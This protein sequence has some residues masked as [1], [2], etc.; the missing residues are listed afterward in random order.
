[1]IWRAHCHCESCRRA[2]SSPVTTFFAVP[3][4]GF[5]FAGDEPGAYVSSP[6][7]LRR[8]C[9]TCGSPMS[10]EYDSAPEEIHLHAASLDD[11]RGFTAERHDFWNERRTWLTCTDDL[12]KREEDN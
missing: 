9:R 8:F 11:D 10:F 12:P 1:M 3:K 6:G 7:R 2:T 5:S 4:Q